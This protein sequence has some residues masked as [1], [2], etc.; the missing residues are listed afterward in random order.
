MKRV[1]NKKMFNKTRSI[2]S[3]FAIYLP[4]TL[5]TA[6][7]IFV[8]NIIIRIARILNGNHYD[9]PNFIHTYVRFYTKYFS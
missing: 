5:I 1:F 4:L 6:P 8:C 7:L 2:I 9:T 3:F